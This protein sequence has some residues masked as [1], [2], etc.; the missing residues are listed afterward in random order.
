MIRPLRNK[1]LFQFLEETSGP[2]NTFK[3]KTN[4]GFELGSSYQETS[5]KP[6]WGVV[7]AAGPEV[8]DE[9]N[10]PGTFILIEPLMWSPG[11]G[12][13]SSPI[14]Q[15]EEEKILAYTDEIPNL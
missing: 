5:S 4:W 11:F 15:T 14:W 6:R 13:I 1:I 8:G 7:L 10:I 12:D 3:E 2:N 9:C